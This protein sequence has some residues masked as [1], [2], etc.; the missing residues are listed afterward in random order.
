MNVKKHLPSS[1]SSSSLRFLNSVFLK[2]TLLPSIPLTLIAI[3]S[4]NL[5][6]WRGS[7]V[8]HFY[9]E[10]V[11]VLLSS[12]LAIYCITRAY[13]LTD[14]FS[15]FLGIGFLTSA[16]I[17]LFH[18]A[19]SYH[20]AENTLFLK[21]FIPQTWFA[22]RTFISAM[23]VIA[24]VKYAKPPDIDSNA[25][26]ASK[27]GKETH[28]GAN[29]MPTETAANPVVDNK[30]FKNNSSGGKLRR[31]LVISLA[32]LALLSIVV[33]T[34]SFFTVFPGVVIDD[35]FLH[36]P[37]EIP[38]L[39]LF[40]AAL[41]FFYKKR[42]HLT[43]DFFYKG[44]L[45]ALIIDVFS[46]MVMSYSASA[47][48]TP[49]NLAHVLKN[50]SYF[51]VII[52][53]ALSGIQ[54]NLELRKTNNRLKEREEV[55]R[56]QY[57]KLK[58]SDKIQKEFI[59]VAAHELRTPIQTIL[60]LT[61]MVH[62]RTM[63]GTDDRNI[64]EVV[65]RNAR[66]LNKMADDILDVTRIESHTLNLRKE[67]F[68]LSETLQKTILDFENRI[69]NESKEN[70]RRPIEI[71]YNIKEQPNVHNH[72][73]MVEADKARISQVLSNLLNN[74]YAS[75]INTKGREAK[76]IGVSLTEEEKKG[77]LNPKQGK[78]EKEAVAVISICDD[79][80]GIEEELA[81]KLFTKFN[82]G[83][84]GGIGLGLYIAKSIIEAHGGEIWCKN[85]DDGKGATFSFSLPLT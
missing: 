58:E 66:R 56:T 62:S 51:V 52:G 32:T 39:V 1:S 18:G 71:R 53:L 5:N 81:P 76:F 2:Y 28:R 11:A 73:L 78:R 36:R 14:T 79:G 38:S 67:R 21:H 42:L 10:M 17:D 82:S 27:S 70:C 61:G 46:Q 83:W 59:K 85:N 69:R 15:L 60:G 84:Y 8:H 12:I 35:Y 54:Y 50:A 25:S 16:L 29:Q 44:L 47:F 7:D 41:I 23:M 22:G 20:S 26:I 3:L 9:F 64:A 24:I 75:V 68:N 30:G 57:E 48:D 45:G 31:A 49:H 72:I 19:L 55:I 43:Q 37:Y 74:A 77:Q 13:S 6:L 40:S 80:K 34:V 65:V 4:F 33:A 63:E